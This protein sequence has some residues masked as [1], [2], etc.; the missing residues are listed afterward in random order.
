MLTLA[1]RELGGAGKPP[2]VL[3]HGLLGSSR[4]WLTAGAALAERHEVV[5]LDARN[6]GRSPHNAEMS[7]PAM[8][9]DLLR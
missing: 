1:A 4:N 3:L 9:A 6:H 8:T 5:A 7:Y 2:L